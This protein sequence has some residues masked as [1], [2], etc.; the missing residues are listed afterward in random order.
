MD[1]YY[2]SKWHLNEPQ[3]TAYELAQARQANVKTMTVW[4]VDNRR[5]KRKR[6][7]EWR[8]NRHGW[9]VQQ[10]HIISSWQFAWK[11]YA[12]GCPPHEQQW[13]TKE[14]AP[15]YEAERLRTQQEDECECTYQ[16]N[17]NGQLSSVSCNI[18]WETDWPALAE[19]DSLQYTRT[20]EGEKASFAKKTHVLKT[21]TTTHGYY[22]RTR[23]QDEAGHQWLILRQ[24]VIGP[25]WH[26]DTAI[27]ISQHGTT[28]ALLPYGN[29]NNPSRYRRRPIYRIPFD[30][31]WWKNERLPVHPDSIF[32]QRH[33]KYQELD[34]KGRIQYTHLYG[35]DARVMTTEYHY[36]SHNLPVKRVMLL[37]RHTGDVMDG[38]A[39]MEYEYTYYARD[40]K[41]TI[42]SVAA[43]NAFLLYSLQFSHRIRVGANW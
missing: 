10:Y 29:D 25:V 32:Y 27:R 34:D 22:E 4:L 3:I 7:R 16:Y 33:A 35:G 30:S 26:L 21:D 43:A 24:P 1:H 28:K 6:I 23:N 40:Q 8:F 18:A 39:Q 11:E 36:N 38:W 31:S 17:S 13:N 15:F 42:D 20:A 2:Y 9:P 41:P 37:H 19:F 14:E 12:W 5:N